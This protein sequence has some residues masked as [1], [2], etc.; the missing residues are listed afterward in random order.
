MK[1]PKTSASEISESKVLPPPIIVVR[2]PV[3]PTI[4]PGVVYAKVTP[5]FSESVK[6]S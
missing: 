5:V 3:A 6:N 4:L 2:F 1:T